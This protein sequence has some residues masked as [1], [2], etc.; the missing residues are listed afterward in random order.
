MRNWNHSSNNNQLVLCGHFDSTYEE[1]KPD[2]IQ[3]SV[4][5]YVNFD[6]TYEELKPDKIQ[7]SVDGYVNFDSTYEE[8]KPL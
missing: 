4:D 3:V 5:G 7:V 8:L 2:K 6:S 1:L